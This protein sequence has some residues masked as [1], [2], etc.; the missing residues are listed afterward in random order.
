M[1]IREANHNDIPAIV[2]LLKSSLGENLMPKSEPYWRWKHIENP[3][4]E[5]P[6]LLALENNLLVGVRAFMRWEWSGK[7]QL[8]KAVRAVDTATHPKHQGKGIFKKL[9]LSLVERCSN[10]G[11]HF[12]FNTPNSQS[13]PGY[14]KMGWQLAGKLPISIQIKKPIGIIKNVLTGGKSDAS[15]ADHQ[16]NLANALEHQGLPLLLENVASKKNFIATNLSIPYLRWRYVEVPVA[17]YSAI[18]LEQGNDLT[19]LIIFRVK[20]TRLGKELRITECLMQ[21]DSAVRHGKQKLQNF[22]REHGIDYVTFSGTGDM[23]MKQLLGVFAVKAAIG[24]MVT[25]RPL[26]VK[27]MELFRNFNTWSPSLGDLE[28]F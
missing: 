24:P 11:T 18:N 28:L 14:L 17:Q 4:G 26:Q 27:E 16:I 3:F 25:V 6:V 15:S 1:E 13:Q 9:T 8:Y 2:A 20:Q 12:I 5:S 10:A 22:V 23:H 7:E 19:G 21:T